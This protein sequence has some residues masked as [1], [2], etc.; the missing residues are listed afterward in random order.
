MTD[1]ATMFRAVHIAIKGLKPK[2][3][4][5]E[6]HG[7]ATSCKVV[8]CW[9]M[10]EFVYAE[11]APSRL[12]RVIIDNMD[13]LKAWLRRIATDPEFRRTLAAAQNARRADDEA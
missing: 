11:D 2:D 4:V 7:D 10:E 5:M 3:I 1:E 9:G 13:G 6:L 12:H 8:A